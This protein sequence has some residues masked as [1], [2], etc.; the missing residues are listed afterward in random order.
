MVKGTLRQKLFPNDTKKSY[1]EAAAWEKE[2]R[3]RLE[4]ELTAIDS[5]TILEWA[6]AY[7][8]DVERRF[9][10]KTYDEKRRAFACLLKIFSPELPVEQLSTPQ[11]VGKKEI[12]KCMLYLSEQASKRSGYAANKDRKNLAAAWKWGWKNLIGFP[13]NTNPFQAVDKFPEERSDRYVPPEEDFWKVYD[14][15]EGQD[16]V[17]LL[18]A[19]HLAARRGEIF[20]LTW[21]DVGFERSQVR[22]WTS[23]REG[24]TREFD[25]LPMTSEL[26]ETLFQWWQSRPIKDTIHVFVCLEKTPF[27]E[28]FYGKPFSVRQHFMKKLCDKV[29][30]NPFGFHAIRHLTAS[31][32]YWKG[33]SLGHIQAVL[34]H[35]NPNTTKLYL[36]S[37]GLEHVREALEE[38]LKRPAQVIKLEKRQTGTK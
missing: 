10:H 5:W 2:E 3:L 17:M 4:K 20:G 11:I 30:V 32:L 14:K 29:G 22:L 31:I 37:L 18:T 12:N 1:R 27:C 15:A 21:S 19:L 34:R 9:V 24:G 38:G 35:K 7:L 26:R 16:K 33:Y 23:K 25:W 36:K 13:K 28:R 6:E 8:N